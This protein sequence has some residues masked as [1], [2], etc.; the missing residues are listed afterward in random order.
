V[1]S[2]YFNIGIFSTTF[3]R[4]SNYLDGLVNE[5]KYKEVDRVIKNPNKYEV[6]LKNGD[7]YKALIANNKARGLRFNKVY[8]DKLIANEEIKNIIFPMLETYGNGNAPK[9]IIFK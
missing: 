8:I 2:R 7:S 9:V 4:A 5:M 3:K 1:N 6:F